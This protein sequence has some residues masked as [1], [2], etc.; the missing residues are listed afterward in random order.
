[1]W[2]AP[3]AKI[4]EITQQHNFAFVV[5]QM[6]IF[7]S[8]CV[9]VTNKALRAV[10]GKEELDPNC[11]ACFHGKANSEGGEQATLPLSLHHT[12]VKSSKAFVNMK[13]CV[14]YMILI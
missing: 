3:D 4:P 12:H 14:P 7:C 13:R 11:N 5:A 8:Y 2:F 10:G 9:W 6:E 1:M